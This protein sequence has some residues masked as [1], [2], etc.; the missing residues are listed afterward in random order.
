MMDKILVGI[1]IGTSSVKAAAFDETGVLIGKTS[2]SI[3]IFN[4]QP[5]WAEQEPAQ[6]WEVVCTVLKELTRGVDPGLIAAVGLSGQCPGHVLVDA[7]HRPLGRAIIW[8]DHRAIEEGKW[9]SEHISAEQAVEWIGS[10]SLSDSSCPPARLL[11]LNRHRHSD[12]ERSIAI[13]QPKDFIALNLTGK[14]TTDPCSAYCLAN[15][16][17]NKYDEQYFKALGFP[18]KLMPPVSKATTMAGKVTAAASQVTGLKAGTPVII[19]TID[20]YCDNL[21]GGVLYPG[22]AVDVAGTSEIISLAIPNKLD[23]PAVY[24]TCLDDS[25][26]WL[27][28][29]LQ[30]GGD[31]LRWLAH[32]FY[33]E[34]G[35]TIRYDLMEKEAASVPA[36]SGG[37][38][39]LPYLCGERAPIWDSEAKGAFIGVTS[40]HSRQHFSRA[41]YESIGFAIRHTLD[42]SEAAAGFVAKDFVVCGG[43]SRS[44]FWNQVKA[45]I[46]QRTVTPTVETQTGCL[47]AAI[48]A[49]VGVGIYHNLKEA[50]GSM[51]QIKTAIEPNIENMNIYEKLYRWYR[52]YY[53]ALK[54]VWTRKQP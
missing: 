16:Q 4:P 31:V 33:P 2:A 22:R 11:W 21:A 23:D 51:I 54:T 7:Q 39:F 24:A 40:D 36:G 35:R 37:L 10:S 29:P 20:A 9:L 19:G 50:C 38:V 42:I 13:L 28:S 46:L 6:W 41:V 12:I 30:C 43:G 15:P 34:F 49:G 53:P 32:C 25:G 45:D 27:C 3:D 17:N 8:S 18:I 47:G 52:D 44:Q 48:L 1:D 14:I 26:Y 5:G